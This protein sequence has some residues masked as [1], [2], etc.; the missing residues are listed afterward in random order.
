MGGSGRHRQQATQLRA[1]WHPIAVSS[2]L[3][4]KPL[5]RRLCG[6]RMVLFRDAA[7]RARAIAAKCP[8]RGANMAGGR[9]VRGCIEC[10]YHGWT[11]DGAG[12][13]VRVP[14]NADGADIPA[15]FATR[16]YEIIEQQGII[17]AHVGD[18][19]KAPAPPPTLAVL[20]D[21]DYRRFDVEQVVPGPF[22]WWV[23][24]FLNIAH[25][26]F[27]HARTYGGDNP[28]VEEFPVDHWPGDLGFSTRFIV[29][30]NYGLLTRM[31]HGR[32]GTFHEDIQVDHY[33]PGCTNSLIDVGNDRRQ[34][35]VFMA[36]PID[37]DTTRIW[38]IASRNYLKRL[39][40]A[41]ELGKL[42]TRLVIREDVKVVERAITTVSIQT[43]GQLSCSA[44]GPALAFEQLVR[45]WNDRESSASTGTYSI[46][47]GGTP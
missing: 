41:D 32:L 30:H 20:D 16:S 19:A 27:T 6:E 8:H 40:L 33:M 35:L 34:G 5:E 12:R 37:G 21:P 36:S 10:P 3:G 15:S 42:Y 43:P 17:W 1:F 22:D 23:E 14:S 39:P 26:T 2:L 7:G 46:E 25:I 4:K 44:D 28:V 18:P 13:C 47:D 45:L 9:V 24:N 38:F 11:F 29:H 31:I